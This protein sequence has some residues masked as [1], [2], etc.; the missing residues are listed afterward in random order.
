MLKDSRL[1]RRRL[2][3]QALGLAAL[4]ALA[5]LAAACGQATPAAPAKPDAPAAKPAADAKPAAPGAAAAAPSAPAK[6]GGGELVYLNQSRGQLKA[7]EA[8]ALR[9]TEQTGTKVT[10]D[11]PGPTDY[12]QKLQAAANA[13]NMPDAFYAIG[14]ADMAPYYKAGWAPNLK[15]ELDKGWNKNWAPGLL[16]FVE[17]LPDNLPG[18]GNLDEAGAT[19]LVIYAW[20]RLFSKPR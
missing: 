19:A 17:F 18:I 12:P 6:A 16:D 20:R 10:I 2:L 8:L 3:G 13:G 5:T 11:S 15:P 1:S 14:A 7:M 4:P 9:Y